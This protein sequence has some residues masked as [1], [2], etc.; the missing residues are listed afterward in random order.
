[1]EEKD[2][3]AA[4]MDSVWLNFASGAELRRREPKTIVQGKGVTVT[5]L[6]GHEVIG[7]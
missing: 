4:A 5:D 6:D 7:A 3:I 1:M 2:L